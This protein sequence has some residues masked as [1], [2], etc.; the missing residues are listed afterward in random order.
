MR[1]DQ[2]SKSEA[3]THEG[4]FL[5]YSSLSKAFRVFNISRNCSCHLQRRPFIHDRFDH[6]SSILNELTYSPSYPVP[7]FLLNDYEPV[8]PNIDQFIS[9]QPITKDQPVILD[10]VEPSNQEDSTQSNTNESSNLRIPQDHPESQIIRDINYGILTH[11]IVSNNFCM[12]VNVVIMIEP[13]NVIDALKED[14]WIK[15]M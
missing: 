8:V 14:E 6:P 1:L 3:N 5:G 13:K 9:S 2:L 10:E 12:F 11:R 7:D 15:V 4:I